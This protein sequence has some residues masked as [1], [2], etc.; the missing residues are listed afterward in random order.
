MV[1]L[2][3]VLSYER[4]IEALLLM[5]QCFDSDE[6]RVELFSDAS[7]DSVDPFLR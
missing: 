7:F 6:L 4:R 1:L 5:V 2:L 3:V